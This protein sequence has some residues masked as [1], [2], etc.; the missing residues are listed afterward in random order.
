MKASACYVLPNDLMLT[1]SE[2]R[3]RALAFVSRLADQQTGDLK[4]IDEATIETENVWVFSYNS[5]RYVETRDP[6]HA[7][8]G[9]APL[10]VVK[11]SGEVMSLGT[12]YPVE[13]YLRQLEARLTG[14][15]EPMD[16]DDFH[17]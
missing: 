16:N 1:Q 14:R 3:E 7:L 9:N 17:H 11:Q 10:I 2:A 15:I 12:A 8:A 13:H 4:L 6:V 5:A